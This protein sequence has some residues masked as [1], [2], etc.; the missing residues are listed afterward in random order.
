VP[1]RVLPPDLLKLATSLFSVSG[2]LPITN[3]IGMVGVAVLAASAAGLAAGHG[4]YGHTAAPPAIPASKIVSTL[5]ATSFM[6]SGGYQEIEGV[7]P[8]GVGRAQHR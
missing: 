1:S 2:W 5:A 4:D 3:T 7:P 8:G 6:S